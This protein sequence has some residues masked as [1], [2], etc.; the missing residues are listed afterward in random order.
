MIDTL[1]NALTAKQT[2]YL[3]EQ[4]ELDTKLV[5]SVHDDLLAIINGTARPHAVYELGHVNNVVEFDYGR[6]TASLHPAEEDRKQ[7]LYLNYVDGTVIRPGTQTIPM[8]H[9]KVV[10]WLGLKTTYGGAHN[11]YVDINGSKLRIKIE[12]N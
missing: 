7:T 4:T 2:S 3:A 6:L 11:C 1:V 9:R 5:N 10:E 8:L 12:F